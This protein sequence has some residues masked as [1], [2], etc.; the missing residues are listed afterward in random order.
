[1]IRPAAYNTTYTAHFVRQNFGYAET[2]YMLE[3][4]YAMPCRNNL[5][6]GKLCQKD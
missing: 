6:G 1:M 3:P 5:E 4:L 2:S